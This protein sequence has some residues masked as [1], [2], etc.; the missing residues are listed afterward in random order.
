MTRM[1]APLAAQMSLPTN[2][3]AT[4]EASPA[5]EVRGPLRDLGVNG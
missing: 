2:L 3:W 4:V 5:R 1:Q